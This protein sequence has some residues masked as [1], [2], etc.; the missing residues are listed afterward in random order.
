MKK[1]SRLFVLQGFRTCS[2]RGNAGEKEEEE[3]EEEE[4]EEGGG[5][6]KTVKG[7]ER[8]DR[9]TRFILFSRSG[10]RSVSRILL[11]TTRSIEPLLRPALSPAA[12]IPRS[13][14]GSF[15]AFGPPRPAIM[16]K[17]SVRAFM[18]RLALKK[19]GPLGYFHTGGLRSSG[20]QR[21]R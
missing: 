4:A 5:V 15:S 7:K 14:R 16:H 17:T 21:M 20:W 6:S 9:G 13:P 2:S 12:F 1:Y 19:C 18:Q 8:R 10:D 11:A 3:E